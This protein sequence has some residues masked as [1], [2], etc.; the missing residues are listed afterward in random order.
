MV[1]ILST[2]SWNVYFALVKLLRYF[3]VLQTLLLLKFLTVS[4]KNVKKRCGQKMLF[5]IL[6]ITL[7]QTSAQL[8][9]TDFVA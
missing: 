1:W 9:L 7:P 2:A 5:V 6:Y 4:Y 8:T 3:A